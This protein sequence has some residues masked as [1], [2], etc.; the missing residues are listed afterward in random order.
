MGHKAVK[1]NYSILFYLERWS[2]TFWV[3]KTPTTESTTEPFHLVKRL[4]PTVR[5]VRE[6]IFIGN[7]AWKDHG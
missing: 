7:E 6:V 3:R 2:E 5:N 1:W 4:S